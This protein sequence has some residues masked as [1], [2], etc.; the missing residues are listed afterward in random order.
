MDAGRRSYPLIT[1]ASLVAGTWCMP[2]MTVLA[3]P[4]PLVLANDYEDADIDLPT[5]WVSEKYDGVR[6]LRLR[7]D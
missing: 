2:I 6:A 1:T 4:P 3:E 5:Y 7:T